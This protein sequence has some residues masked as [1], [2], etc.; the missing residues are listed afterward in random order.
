MRRLCA[1]ATRRSAGPIQNAST[2]E[3]IAAD[4]QVRTQVTYLW[5][6]FNGNKRYDPGEVFPRANMRFFVLKP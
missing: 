4:P 2:T 5:H 1:A 3:P 6:D